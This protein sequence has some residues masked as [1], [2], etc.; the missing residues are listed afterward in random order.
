MGWIAFVL[1]VVAST[2]LSLELPR[3]LWPRPHMS[4]LGHADPARLWTVPLAVGLG[5][6]FLAGLL[7]V[8]NGGAFGNGPVSSLGFIASF[9]GA[10][11]LFCLPLL[12]FIERGE[13]LN[14]D[15][16]SGAIHAPEPVGTRM[17]F[18]FALGVAFI[19][20]GI[21]LIWAGGA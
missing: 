19:A 8:L 6:L 11:S 13:D 2:A 1:L 21:L 5:A 10:A 4:K 7:V 9:V 16:G 20:A 18:G 15:D 12:Y 14:E 3:A 17:A